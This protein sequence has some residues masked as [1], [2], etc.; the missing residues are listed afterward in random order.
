MF[1][2]LLQKREPL[3]VCIQPQLSQGTWAWV[4][5]NFSQPLTISGGSFDKF[6]DLKFDHVETTLAGN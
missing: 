5:M 3:G 4:F 2:L 1:S 6:N